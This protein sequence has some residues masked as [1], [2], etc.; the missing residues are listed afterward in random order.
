M[1][2]ITKIKHS[3]SRGAYLSHHC[4]NSASDAFHWTFWLFWGHCQIWLPGRGEPAAAPYGRESLQW[5]SAAPSACTALC[6]AGHLQQQ[7][8]QQ[9]QPQEPQ[10]VWL[11]AM[12]PVRGKLVCVH[13]W[14]LPAAAGLRHPACLGP[15]PGCPAIP[16]CWQQQQYLLPSLLL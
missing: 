12:D 1:Y 9:K 15:G 13:A 4:R 6:V 11:T 16:S 5:C 7:S 8:H 14:P 10:A 3:H 2:C